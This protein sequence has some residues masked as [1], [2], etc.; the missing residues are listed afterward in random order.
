[1]HKNKDFFE[2]YKTSKFVIAR[3]KEEARE[4]FRK[5]ISNMYFYRQYDLDK[6]LNKMFGYVNTENAITEVMFRFGEIVR[7]CYW[8]RC[9]ELL[10]SKDNVLAVGEEDIMMYFYDMNPDAATIALSRMDEY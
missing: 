9:F 1:M 3:K 7:V 5:R 2:G 6:F 4:L 10:D 8:A